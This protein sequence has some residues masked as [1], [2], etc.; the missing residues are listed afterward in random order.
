MA[1]KKRLNEIASEFGDKKDISIFVGSDKIYPDKT[2]SNETLERLETALRSPESEQGSIRVFE[3]KEL[4]Y[5]S[6]QSQITLDDKGIAPKFQ[7]VIEQVE[8]LDVA[9]QEYETLLQ[10]VPDTLPPQ[11]RD[12]QLAEVALA[13]QVTPEKYVNLLAHSPYTQQRLTEG[14]PITDVTEFYLAPKMREYIRAQQEQGTEPL[15]REPG[16]AIGI[17]QSKQLIPIP[18]N[19]S[20]QQL[21]ET[22]RE[23]LSPLGHFEPL[24]QAAPANTLES[25]GHTEPLESPTVGGEPDAEQQRYDLMNPPEAVNQ[26]SL[27]SLTTALEA[28]H[29]RIDSL[30][31]QLSETT[32]ALQELSQHVKDSQFGNWATSKAQEVAKTSQVIAVQAKSKIAQWMSSKTTAVKSFAQEKLNEGKAVVSDKVDELK[33]QTQLKVIETKEALREQVNDILAP[34][35]VA[36][37]ETSGRYVVEMY[38][39]GQSY[40]KAASYSFHLKD[41]SVSVVRQSDQAV[42]YEKGELTKSANNWDIHALK[43]LPGQ[44]ERANSNALQTQHKQEAEMGA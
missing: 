8:S 3:G 11:E 24:G 29:A 36:K 27:S 6:H 19:A 34:V 35:N 44:I 25:L 39:D 12:E 18:V 15:S 41:D 28:A 42:I 23:V 21:D 30:Q 16:G 7:P 13:Q 17:A 5:R 9:K 14:T 38:G 26:A 4:I 37:L 22:M 33:I 32:E 31:T 20:E 10:D 43:Y 40:E 2:I 1:N